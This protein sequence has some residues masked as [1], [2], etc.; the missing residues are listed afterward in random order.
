[1]VKACVAIALIGW[2]HG[3]LQKKHYMVRK[4]PA[5]IFP[6]FRSDSGFCLALQCTVGMVG[7]RCWRC[8]GRLRDRDLRRERKTGGRGAEGE[9]ERDVALVAAVMKQRAVGRAG[10]SV[11]L[12][13][14]CSVVLP[15]GP[16]L[17]RRPT[18]DEACPLGAFVLYGGYITGL[19]TAQHH[20]H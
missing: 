20:S 17:K 15:C 7:L 3:W 11:S 13:C 2:L 18:M 14:V 16:L 6:R 12:M 8:G 19:S 10:S 5:V 4:Y 9:V 1:M